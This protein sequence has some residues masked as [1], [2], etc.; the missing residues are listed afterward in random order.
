MFDKTG[1]ITTDQLTAVGVAGWTPYGPGAPVRQG[2]KFQDTADTAERQGSSNGGQGNTS[3]GRGNDSSEGE[4]A[5]AVT[6]EVFAHGMLAAPLEACIVLAGCQSLVDID[7]QLQV[8]CCAR[9]RVRCRF[10]C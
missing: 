8:R 4:T 1:T 2:D 7:G 3:S 6:G 5:S 10:I 9:C